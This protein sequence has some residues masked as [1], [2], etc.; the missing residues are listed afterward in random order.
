MSA[1]SVKYLNNFLKGSFVI[2]NPP[3]VNAAVSQQAKNRPEP[4]PEV[5]QR[6]RTGECVYVQQK[7]SLGRKQAVHAAIKG[8][9][10]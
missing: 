9:R 10:D 6:T 1:L 3:Y 8:L 7:T 5:E 2:K 4:Q